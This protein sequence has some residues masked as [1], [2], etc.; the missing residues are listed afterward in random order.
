MTENV[1]AFHAGDDASINVEVR[2]AY[3]A[4]RYFDDGVARMFDAGIVNGFA[5]NVAF[6]VPCKRFH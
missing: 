5:A 4:G 3:G 2:A 6:P 1:A